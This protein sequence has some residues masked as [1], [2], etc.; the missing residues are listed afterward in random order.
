[1]ASNKCTPLRKKLNNKK[2]AGSTTETKLKG[3][4]D[5]NNKIGKE[6]ERGTK[7]KRFSQSYSFQLLFTNFKHHYLSAFIMLP[8][9]L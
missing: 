8:V 2:T 6:K 1:M 4:S 7:K 3:E 9:T 5:K